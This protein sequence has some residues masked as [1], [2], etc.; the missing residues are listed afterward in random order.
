MDSDSLNKW[1]TLAANVGIVIGLILVVVQ[2]RQNSDLVRTQLVADEY[3]LVSALDAQLVGENPAEA[4]MKAMY[5]PQDM[6]YAD[7]RI[8]DAYLIVRIDVLHRLYRLGQEG[9][10]G[11][12]DWKNSS[13]AFTFEWLFGTE[14]SRLWWEHIGRETYQASPEFVEYMDA[15][16]QGVRENRSI[17][18]WQAI[19]A[20]LQPD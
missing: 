11:K 13:T 5:S 16:I 19:Q 18:G 8:N 17:K 20:D 12:D 3:A 14:F 6:T 1:L 4:L 9:L 10:F 2:I 15:R 7:F